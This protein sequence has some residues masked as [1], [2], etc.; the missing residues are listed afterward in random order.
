[1][2]LRKDGALLGYIAGYR[3]EVRPFSDKQI[4]LLQKFAAQAVI[5]MENARLL[6]EIRQRQAELRIT[7][8]NMVDGVA[9]FDEALRLAAWNRNFQEL[10][11]LPDEFLA[12]RPD[13][14]TY[15]RYLVE[16]GEFGKTDPETQIARLRAQ[17]G[18]HY[19]FERTR[20]DGTVIEVRHNPMPGGGVVAIY[21][22]ITER[23]R[24]EAEIKAARDTAEAAYRDL[25]AAQASLIQ[26]EKMA[27]LGQLTAG[28]AHEIKNPLN[29]VNNFAGLSVE[30]LDELKETAAS[31]I[32]ALDDDKRAEIDE[33]I[34]LLSGN[35]DRI[36]EH[37]RR[38]DNIVASMLEH[39]RGSSG[40][41]RSVDLNALIEEALNLAYHGGRAQDQS[42]NIT[43]ERD[44]ADTIAPI[45]LVPQDISRVCL[46]LFGNG[47]YAATKRQKEETTGV[48]SP[49]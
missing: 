23:K 19:S 24:S 16:R 27:S 31:A 45:E 38:A 7:F 36:A 14:D 2:P 49:R 4:A 22:D 21:S 33:T 29:F 39:S 48:S 6:D 41:R 13:L 25:K 44:Y 15:I 30:L 12:Q 28:I 8:D 34:A 18:D 5:A 1:V 11:Q 9:M 43:L 47:F 46:N 10:L 40:E 37:G 26:A 3:Q 20:P 32:S 35:L 17:I 42:F